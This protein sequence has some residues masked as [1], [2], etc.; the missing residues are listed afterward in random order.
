MRYPPRGRRSS[1][2]PTGYLSYGEDYGD[3]ANDEICLMVQ[4]ETKE[5]VASAH[6]ILNVEGVDGC[7]IGPSDLGKSLGPGVDKA[8]QARMQL[9]VRDI[10][11]EL[12]RFPGIAAGGEEA[13]QHLRDGFLFVLATGD[14]G[15][16]TEGATRAR[17]W[18]DDVRSSL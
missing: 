8:A 16:L 4:I 14:F 15:I 13:E 12:G 10:C 6:E 18:L 7:M 2:A 9:Q 1:G 11:L 17:G 3:A 5:A